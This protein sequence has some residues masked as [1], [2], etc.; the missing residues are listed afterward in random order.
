MA[1]IVITG[2]NTDVGKTYATAALAAVASDMGV[3]VTVVKPAQTGEPEGRG[4]LATVQQLCPAVE[5][6]VEFARYPEPLA[7]NISARRAG[8]AHLELASTVE[9]IAALDE[10]GRLVLVEGAGGL[11][12]RI[13]DEW[14]IAD[15][16]AG[17]SAPL[18]IVT[19]VGLGSLNLAELSVEAARARGIE[20][21]GLIGGS[22]PKDPDLATRLNVDEFSVVTHCPYVA[23]VPR[24][25]ARYEDE[26]AVRA[27]IAD[28]TGS[29]D[30]LGG[31]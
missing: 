10:P 27:L 21:L 23:S 4:D 8:M 13:A 25:S 28:L 16:A 22:V 17:L 2:T 14:T 12:V 15:V 29:G 3:A 20:V 18:L 30:T 24:G 6:V 5:Q 26:T 19:S 7:P 31:R 9:N 1:I 11:L